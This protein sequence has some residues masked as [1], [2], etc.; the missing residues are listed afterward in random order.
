VA[1]AFYGREDRM[2]RKALDALLS[3]ITYI[4]WKLYRSHHPSG[5]PGDEG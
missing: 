1:F 2:L 5:W 3:I 4:P